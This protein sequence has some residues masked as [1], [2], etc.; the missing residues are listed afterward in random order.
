MLIMSAAVNGSTGVS[1]V[2]IVFLLLGLLL[3]CAAII[4]IDRRL[5]DNPTSSDRAQAAKRRK[6]A[7][8]QKHCRAVT[9]SGVT[10]VKAVGG[11]ERSDTP[12][13][14]DPPKAAISFGGDRENGS[15]TAA[16]ETTDT[17]P[18]QCE[19]GGC[20][21]NDNIFFGRDYF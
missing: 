5:R 12:K 7:K 21:Q 3:V 8:K 17:E 4:I 1:T 6:G 16:G 11:D 14:P 19:E 9:N 13:D 18:E 15:W 2:Q 20:Y 10:A